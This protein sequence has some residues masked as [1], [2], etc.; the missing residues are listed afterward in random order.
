MV[1][2]DLAGSQLGLAVGGRA[3]LVKDFGYGLAVATALGACS[4]A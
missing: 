1:A 3:F 4:A 2:R